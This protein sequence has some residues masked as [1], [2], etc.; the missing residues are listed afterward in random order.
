[1]AVPSMQPMSGA[2]LVGPQPDP[3]AEPASAPVRT[4]NGTAAPDPAAT[5]RPH[6]TI[7]GLSKR[8]GSTVIYDK[9]DLDV[10]RGELISI[11][12][13]NG[14][15]KSTLINMIAGLIRPD[16]G[17]VL[18]DGKLLSEVKFHVFQNTARRCSPGWPTTTSPIP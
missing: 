9:F 5:G 12:G 10:P 18:L 14:C 13:P 17:E 2:A 15:G 11:F 8:F 6:V 4:L 16:A 3:M 7:R 1:M